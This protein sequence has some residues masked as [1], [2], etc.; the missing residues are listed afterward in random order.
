MGHLTRDLANHSGS[1]VGQDPSSY[2]AAH[3]K[4]TADQVIFYDAYTVHNLKVGEEHPA[5]GYPYDIFRAGL[6]FD[7]TSIPP[8]A[9]T[10]SAVLR[11]VKATIGPSADLYLDV[12]KGVL[13]SDSQ[14]SPGDYGALLGQTTPRGSVYIGDMNA[15]P[16]QTDV[17]LDAAGRG[18]VVGGGVT[19]FGLRTSQDIN[20]I[21]SIDQLF[22]FSGIQLILRYESAPDVRTDPAAD[23]H[24]S[25][26]TLRGY[27]LDDGELTTTVSFEYGLTDSYGRSTESE[28]GGEGTFSKVVTGLYPR[29]LYHFRAVAANDRGTVFGI[30][31]TFATP[32]QKGSLWVDDSGLLAWVDNDEAERHMDGCSGTSAAGTPGS[33]SIKGTRLQWFDQ[34]EWGDKNYAEG[35][36]EAGKLAGSLRIKGRRLYYKDGCGDS[37]YVEGSTFQ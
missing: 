16:T 19:R 29:S 13:G 11:L 12:V 7:T 21:E 9:L 34:A 25:Q 17:E 10:T 36:F 18:E 28:V 33:L 1:V 35:T 5:G 32:R 24:G 2:F 22:S 26:A 14:V 20:A 6:L 30:D 27:L 31:R 3:N 8:G 23:L 15:Y 37:R 4:M